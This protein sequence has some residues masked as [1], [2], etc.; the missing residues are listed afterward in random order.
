MIDTLTEK[1]PLPR[2]VIAGY[3]SGVGKT[4][5]ATGIMAAFRSSGLKVQ[6]F[7]I[8]PDYIDPSYHTVAAGRISRNL[9]SWLTG[10]TQVRDGFAQAARQAD[11]AIIEGVMGLYDGKEV[12][13]RTVGSTVEMAK[14]LD[15]PVILVLDAASMAQSAAAIVL[16]F[17]N[18][19][20]GVRLAGVI[21][22]RVGSDRHY[23]LLFDSIS[24]TTGLPVLGRIA[25]DGRLQ[26]PS[27]HLGLIPMAERGEQREALLALGNAIRQAVN[28]PRLMEIAQS[29][30]P[31]MVEKTAPVPAPKSGIT[32][33][34]ARDEAFCFYYEEMLEDLRVRGATLAEFSPLRDSAL[35]AD[36]AGL[37]IGGGFP[38]VFL[39]ELA[40]NK[41]LQSSL[42]REVT[43]GMPVY[44]ECGGLMY[45][46]AEVTDLEGRTRPL[47]GVV[48]GRC[49]MG[50]RLAGM[51]YLAAQAAAGNYLVPSGGIINGHEFHYSEFMPGDNKLPAWTLNGGRG[52]DGRRDGFAGQRLLA[53]Y[54]H[55]NW[56]GYPALTERFLA[57]A[58]QYGRE[59]RE[60]AN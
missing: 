18:Y 40:A 25:R 55:L 36:A 32:I 59:K 35:P 51:G 24:T 57:T 16:G 11:V 8:G 31:L 49:V 15:A 52:S 22:N 54:V 9:D 17:K 30:P 23:Q 47:I 34:L 38:E 3:K 46:T 53:S 6:P 12:T 50:N 5:I 21:L 60:V 4:A 43:A 58:R 37:I 48:P 7:K 20:P 28:L 13:G 39:D 33:A 2:L 29:A 14:L 45:L 56:A 10:P 27:R 44:A 1:L 42:H 26:L 19:D 41:L